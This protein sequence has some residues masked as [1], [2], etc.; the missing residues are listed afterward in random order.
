MSSAPQLEERFLMTSFRLCLTQAAILAGFVGT[1]AYGQGLSSQD[2]KFMQDA[3][4]G[5]MKEVH[6]GHMGLEKGTSPGVKEF[7]QHLINDHTKGNE[8]LTALAKQ[9]SVTLPADDP[10]SADSSSVAKKTGADFDKAFAKDMVEDHQKDIAEFEK[11][12]KSGSDPDVKNWANKTLPT[13]RS[14][15]MEAQGLAK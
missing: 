1:L 6:M 5:G 9:K 14:H 3:A 11:E 10:K 13:L 7:S 15:L 8:E 2:R 12:A 4:K